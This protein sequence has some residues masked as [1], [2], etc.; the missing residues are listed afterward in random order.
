MAS[1]FSHVALG[2]P[3]LDST[4]KNGPTYWYAD[5]TGSKTDYAL[6]TTTGNRPAR[7]PVG[8]QNTVAPG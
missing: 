7:Q 2:N 4:V 6:N 8:T 1:F 3:A 5:D